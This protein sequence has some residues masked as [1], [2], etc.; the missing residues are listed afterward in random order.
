MSTKAAGRLAWTLWAL[1]VAAAVATL[2]AAAMLAIGFAT[3]GS[4]VASRQPRSAVGWLLLASAL[5]FMAELGAEIYATEG[6]GAAI[7]AAAWFAGWAWNVLLLVAAI[8]LPLFFPDGHLLSSRSRWAV[9][10][11][12]ASV[13]LTI[14]A[15]A[16]RPGPLDINTR[17]PVTN[18]L[19]LNGNAGDAM[20]AAAQLG[21][22]ALL[23]TVL[24][25]AASLALRLRRSRGRERAQMKWF[26]LLGVLTLTAQ[27]TASL[28][29][30]A[31]EASQQAWLE[32]VSGL[33]FLTTLALFAVGLPLAIGIAILRHRLYD[34]DVVIKRTLVYSAVTATLVTTYLVLV[35]LLQAALN[36]VTR[37]SDLAVATS[38][39]AVAALFRP[40]RTRIQR[41]VDRRF[42]RQRYDA[43]QTLERFAGHLRDGVDL[44]TLGTNLRY[45]VHEAMQP[46][47]VSLWVR[48]PP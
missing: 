43:V 23:G 38:T 36:P 18:P 17:S 15:L 48:T 47:H 45:A 42:F 26:A 28:G 5:A 2:S 41:I 10:L 3:V 13:C 37:E 32:V 20:G 25:A 12:V 39:L 6:S 46:A 11:G 34:I 7:T 9:T 14:V 40:V 33:G 8:L 22:A 31:A 35:L 24:L 44:E 21:S 29:Q 4:L 1:Y 30:A 27:A 16:L 19:G